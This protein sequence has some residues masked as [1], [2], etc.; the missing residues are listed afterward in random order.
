MIT[1]TELIKGMIGKGSRRHISWKVVFLEWFT[2]Q[3]AHS[4]NRVTN[5][6][7]E[8]CQKDQIL[9]IRGTRNTGNTAI[10]TT[11]ALKFSINFHEN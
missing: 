8:F 6:G 7:D 10:A 5:S 3:I 11:I 1:L 4:V 9:P 2:D